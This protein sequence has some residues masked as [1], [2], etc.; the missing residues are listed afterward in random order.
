M[1]RA[2]PAPVFVVVPIDHVVA[3]VLY[4]PVAA[5]CGENTLGA[6]FYRFPA[7]DAVG[8]FGGA[9]A[10]LLLYGLPF[11][12]ERLPHMRE[13]E[14]VVEFGGSPDLPGFDPSMVGGIIGDKIRFLPVFEVQDDV[15]KERGLIPF[16]GKVVM[17]V[18]S[19]YVTGDI[20]LGQKRV[21]GDVLAFNVDGVEEGKS[22]LD[23]VCLLEFVI[24][25]YRQGA[26]FFWVWQVFVS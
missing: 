14:V 6:G 19:D 11:D 22:G 12:D 25:L 26:D 21:R 17:G 8:Y 23:L 3:A 1:P 15:V 16:H 9:C 2:Y 4:A 7:R 10:T 20:L 5:V 24:Y 13:V 18:A